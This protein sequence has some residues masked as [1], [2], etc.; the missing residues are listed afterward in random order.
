MLCH[1][2]L[3]DPR[4]FQSR[5]LFPILSGFTNCHAVDRAPRSA[6]SRNEGIATCVHCWEGGSW[7]PTPPACP[8][9]RPAPP[10]LTHS[11][12]QLQALN[13]TVQFPTSTPLSRLFPLPGMPRLSFFC[14]SPWSLKTAQVL[15]PPEN[16]SV[17]A[18]SFGLPGPAPP[19]P[20]NPK[21]LVTL[22][23][24]YLFIW[25]SSPPG[26]EPIELWVPRPSPGTSLEEVRT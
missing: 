17:K 7:L 10:A 3:D 8:A 5:D 13:F 23:G 15:S 20:T 22:F 18:P 12:L 25:A 4:M 11:G 26:W 16:S 14:P 6:G 1:V 21:T 24:N 2:G 9:S 19:P